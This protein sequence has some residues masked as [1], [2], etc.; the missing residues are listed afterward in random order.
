MFFKSRWVFISSYKH[1]GSIHRRWDRG[2]VIDESDEFVVVASKRAKVIENDGRCWFTKEPA[3]TIFS[4]NQWWN[5]ICMFKEE[6]ICYY[7]NIASPCICNKDSI[8]Y[9]D[10]DLDAKLFPNNEIKILDQKEY[11]RHRQ[12]YHYSDDLDKVLKY[13]TDEIIKMMEYRTFPFNDDIIQEYYDIYNNLMKKKY[14]K[15]RK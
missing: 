4:K 11:L 15:R 9:I 2:L 8:V 10:Y 6:G 5:V 13:Q 1:D 3:V 12:I 14:E 7:C